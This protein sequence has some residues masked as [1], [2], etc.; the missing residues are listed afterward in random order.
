M[1]VQVD[2]NNLFDDRKYVV[3]DRSGTC[4]DDYVSATDDVDECNNRLMLI[5]KIENDQVIDFETEKE[6]YREFKKAGLKF[7]KDF[8][9]F[10]SYHFGL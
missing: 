1:N 8:V 10:R 9:I 4:F 7:G 3:E 6:V 5:S 2:V